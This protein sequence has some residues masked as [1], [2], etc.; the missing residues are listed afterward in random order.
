[1]SFVAFQ[2]RAGRRWLAKLAYFQLELPC[3]TANRSAQTELCGRT[4]RQRGKAEAPREDDVAVA[5]GSSSLQERATFRIYSNF[6]T[7]PIQAAY[8]CS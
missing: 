8:L 2:N 6:M 1:M 4:R 3:H 7:L 5:L